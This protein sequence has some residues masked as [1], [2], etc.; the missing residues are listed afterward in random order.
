MNT[1]NLEKILKG[2]GLLD[3]D[4]QV[5]FYLLDVN[6][7]TISAI[8]KDTGLKRSNVYHYVEELLDMSLIGKTV[9][10][11]RKYLIP[12]DPGA[13]VDF[14]K[15]KK[16]KVQAVGF[17]LEKK[18]NKTKQD[19]GIHYEYGTEGF[20]RFLERL[21][22]AKCGP[23]KA[24]I[25]FAALQGYVSDRY[26]RNFLERRAITKIP[27]TILVSSDERK[28]LLHATSLG[29]NYKAMLEIRSLPKGRDFKTSI[30]VYDDV[31]HFFTPPDEGYIFLFESPAFSRSMRQMFDYMWKFS[32][33]I[34]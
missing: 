1:R 8:A 17:E 23:I 26:I 3:Q 27:M 2:L 34:N 12:E 22:E 11:G 21:L 9:E 15:Q 14:M 6:K 10:R 13:F 29:G 33:N 16:K 30:I 19:V 5:Y 28:S 25:N 4:I 7:A 20:K 31:V 24:Y 32:K 18:F